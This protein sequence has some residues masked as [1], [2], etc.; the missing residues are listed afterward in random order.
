MIRVNEDQ[1][2]GVELFDPQIPFAEAG[3]KAKK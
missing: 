1:T 2:I 3:L